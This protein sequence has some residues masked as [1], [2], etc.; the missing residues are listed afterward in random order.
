MGKLTKGQGTKETTLWFWPLPNPAF[1]E[2]ETL[3][4]LAIYAANI[5]RQL[6]DP[7]HEK[8]IESIR[9]GI[10]LG[11]VMQ[12][13]LE[14]SELLGSVP[15]ANILPF[16]LPG[17]SAAGHK[18]VLEIRRIGGE[19]IVVCR[20]RVHYYE[21]LDQRK[22]TFL[23][24]VLHALGVK[25]LILTQAAGA[26]NP[27]F[28]IGDFVF[29]KGTY[30]YEHPDPLLGIWPRNGEVMFM[31]PSGSFDEKLRDDLYLAACQLNIPC[32]MGIVSLITGPTFEDEGQRLFLAQ[33]ADAAGMSTGNEA[34]VA[35]SLGIKVAGT[36]V[37][38]DQCKPG[39]EIDHLDIVQVAKATQYPM[40]RL[41]LEYYRDP[42]PIS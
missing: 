40:N 7:N 34:V 25:E 28:N 41:L 12:E 38:T 27:N 42:I 29:L 39:I 33:Y 31:D 5:V 3:D 6:I 8:G 21:T 37:L 20:G 15:L 30:R 17:D 10:V 4:G 14:D 2:M 35:K 16:Q 26:L 9:R 18:T 13:V 24:R 19:L 1:I 23:I 32:Q 22:A 11:T 36:A